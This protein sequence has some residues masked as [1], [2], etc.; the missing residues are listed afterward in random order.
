MATNVHHLN[1][2]TMHAY[3]FPREDVR[4]GVLARGHALARGRAVIHCL[5]VETGDGLALVD[6]GWGVGDCVAPSRT[7]RQFASFVG[8]TLDPDETAIRQ[9]EGLGHDPAGVKHIFVTHLHLDHAGG[10]ADFPQAEVHALAV[11][12]DAHARPRSLMER[13]AYRPEHRSHGPRW[14][15]HIPQGDRW[16]GLA[17]APPVR[18]GATEFVMV[19]FP[20]HTRGHCAVAV[21]SGD[22]WLLHCGDLYGYHRQVDPI[23]PYA[24]PC[25]RLMEWMVTTWFKMPRRHWLTLRGLLQ[26]HGDQIRAFCGHDTYEFEALRAAVLAR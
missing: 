17:C 9:I 6:T 2:G 16:F 4:G 1:C 5:L 10:I 20:G 15:A 18:I 3:G 21:G 11:E 14:W 7:V 12:I 19:P 23:Q 25:G 24:H 13:Y 8:C 22:G 26:A